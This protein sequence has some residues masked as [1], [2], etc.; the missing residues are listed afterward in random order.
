VIP[1]SP[2]TVPVIEILT[3]HLMSAEAS[4]SRSGMIMV[5]SQEKVTLRI[6]LAALPVAI[7]YR[8]SRGI[9]AVL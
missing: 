4:A 9:R 2:V 7:Y 6:Y 5:A 3:G 1:E 8:R